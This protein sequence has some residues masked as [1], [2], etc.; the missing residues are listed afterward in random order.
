MVASFGHLYQRRVYLN[1]VPG[2][3]KNDLLAL[4]DT[5]PHD[6]RYVRLVEYTTIIKLLLSSPDPVTFGGKFYKV[7]KLR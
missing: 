7:D 4:N 2:G 6:D 3:F 5:N 1:M